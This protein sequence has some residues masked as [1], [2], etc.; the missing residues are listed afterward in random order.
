M[1]DGAATR[2]RTGWTVALLLLALGGLPLAVW[3]DLTRLSEEQLGRYAGDMGRIID[4][5]R[6]FYANDVA[7]RVLA[8]HGERITTPADFRTTPG[9]I[10]IPASFSLELAEIFKAQNGAI[11]YRF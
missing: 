11:A 3:A 10:P 5:V 4:G 1:G 8:A 2:A 6:G 7:G 9:A